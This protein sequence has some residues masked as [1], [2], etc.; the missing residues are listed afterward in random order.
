MPSDKKFF[1]IKSPEA[2]SATPRVVHFPQHLPGASFFQSRPKLRRQIG[3]AVATLVSFLL[4][5][6]FS[7]VEVLDFKNDA[8]TSAPD[9]YADFKDGAQALFGFDL[10]KA[11]DSF[12][13]ANQRVADLNSQ[14]PLS[15]VPS[16]LGN[17]FKMSQGALDLSSSLLELQMNGLGLLLREN[18]RDLLG[19]FE[20]IGNQLAGMHSVSG[21][22]EEQASSSGYPLGSDFAKM[23]TD[24]ESA[25]EF[26]KVFT[27]WLS[28][29]YKQR[30]LLFFQNPSEMRPGGGFIGSYGIATLFQGRLL[31]LSVRDIY[32]PDGQLELK[33]I[34][35]KPLQGIT[36]TWEARDANWFFDF[37]TSAKK[38]TQFLE[39]SKIYKEQEMTFSGA[40]AVNVGVLE[41]VMKVIGPVELPD[42]GMTITHENFLK[43]LQAEVEAGPDKAK[44]Q[45]KKILSVLTPIIFERIGQLEA[46]QRRELF[47]RFAQRFTNKDVMVY[48]KDPILENYMQKIGA[49]GEVARLP[50]DFFGDYLGIVNASVGGGKSDAMIDQKAKLVSSF[51]EDGRIRNVL[52]LIKTHH[53]D[54][55]EDWWYRATN[56]AYIQLYT[57][58]GSKLTKVTGAT[59]KTVHPMVDYDEY[60]KGFSVDQD[61]NDLEIDS[62]I[63]GKDVFSAWL[64]TKAGTTRSITFDYYSP[65]RFNFQNGQYRLI[66]D[67]QS[68]HRGGLDIEL[69]APLGFYWKESGSSIFSASYPTL[70]SR[71]DLGLTLSAAER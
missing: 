56:R 62:A 50:N 2:K 61:L 10:E 17:L 1:D 40:V 21:A 37:P 68:G 49:G 53:G 41:D 65:Y 38:V 23:K 32:D 5:I 66:I 19:L 47:D 70:P 12:G 42:Y 28:A 22:L 7:G 63:Q 14:A 48:F 34:P 33:V 15:I 36:D 20:R 6:S 60:D 58:N 67:K 64:D 26:L 31:D 54:K 71:I 44:G 30:L 3:G 35:P 51:G 59:D 55:E 43:E 24:L 52:T 8:E 9:I 4:I 25:D 18:G 46:S 39:A 27:G 29:T 13:S 16:V 11:R 45:P 69:Q 57:P